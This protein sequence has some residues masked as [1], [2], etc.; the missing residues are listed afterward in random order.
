MAEETKR[1]IQELQVLEQSLQSLL[2]QK[3]QLQ[4]ELSENSNAI[5][6]VSKASGDIYKILGQVMLK[7]EKNSV[8]KE[9]NDKKKLGD[10]RLNAIE[11]QQGM[12]EEKTQKLQ[13][14][15]SQNIKSQKS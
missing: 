13:K 11:K 5:N 4:I 7:S 15:I 10:L 12:I 3:Q 9:L 8:L 2:M 6:E 14:E 1:K